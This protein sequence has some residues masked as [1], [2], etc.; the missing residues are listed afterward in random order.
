MSGGERTEV[1]GVVKV[2][3][4]NF[5]EWKE[6]L[7]EHCPKFGSNKDSDGRSRDDWL[8]WL[9]IS[10]ESPYAV[11]YLV[12]AGANRDVAYVMRTMQEELVEQMERDKADGSYHNKKYNRYKE[13][14]ED[15][16]RWLEQETRA[17]RM[18][19]KRGNMGGR[20]G[21]RY[22]EYENGI[23]GHRQTIITFKTMLYELEEKQRVQRRAMGER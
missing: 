9:F 15:L 16:N 5:E 18:V 12:P 2:E 3:M 23:I 14:I 4:T 22:D 7:E 6:S 8:E 13:E 19:E 21:V 17:L 1:D 20:N 11:K 10:D